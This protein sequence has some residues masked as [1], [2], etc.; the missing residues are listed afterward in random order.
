[1]PQSILPVKTPPARKAAALLLA[2][3]ALAMV[4]GGAGLALYPFYTDWRAGRQQRTLATQLDTPQSREVYLARKVQDG[5]PLTRII[6]PRLSVDSIVV[7]GISLEALAAG[8]GH[9][10][11]TPLPGEVGNVAIAGHRTMNGKPFANIDTLK[12]GDSIV[13]VTPFAR[14]SYEVVAAFDGHAN[15]WITKPDDW[16]VIEPTTDPMLTLTTC[17]PRGSSK[18]RLVVRAK[19]V[20]TQPV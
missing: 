10:Q 14:H 7:E 1:M 8:A 17:H 13:L 19:L 16:K 4:A 11:M 3:V 6:I 9:Y 2:F 18:Q 20:S 5:K 15:P 12:A